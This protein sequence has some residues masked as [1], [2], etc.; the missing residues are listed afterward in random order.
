MNPMFKMMSNNKF[1]KHLTPQFRVIKE[2]IA[3]ETQDKLIANAEAKRQRRR[4]RNLKNLA[5]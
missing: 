3:Q 5:K 4:E 1:I 2:T